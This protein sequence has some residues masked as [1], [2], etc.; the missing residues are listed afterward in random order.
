MDQQFLKKFLS[1]KT[2]E[3]VKFKSSFNCINIYLSL[4]CILITFINQR[5][6]CPIKIGYKP[7]KSHVRF[8]TYSFSHS[9]ISVSKLRTWPCASSPASVLSYTNSSIPYNQIHVLPYSCY[10]IIAT[11]PVRYLRR[12]MP[13]Q[14]PRIVMA[15]HT[16]VTLDQTSYFSIF[17]FFEFSFLMTEKIVKDKMQ[18]TYL[19]HKWQREYSA[20]Q[21]THCNIPAKGNQR[22]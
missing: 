15:I 6:Y 22:L 14:G 9:I 10:P 18:S 8:I 13:P 7:A 19:K 16:L 17:F 4:L 20:E 3:K 2:L 1:Q 11:C 21:I 12:H 5:H